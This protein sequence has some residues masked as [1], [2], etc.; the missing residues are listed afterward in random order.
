MAAGLLDDD[1]VGDLGEAEL[2]VEPYPVLVAEEQPELRP[3]V[4]RF[5][6][7]RFQDRSSHAAPSM[8]GGHDHAADTHDG[9]P[10]RLDLDLGGNEARGCDESA[11]LVGEADVVALGAI[12]QR[13]PSCFERVLLVALQLI[14]LSC[15]QQSELNDLQ[16]WIQS[17]PL[18]RPTPPPEFRAYQGP[19]ANS[20]E[21]S[22]RVKGR[23]S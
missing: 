20:G 17:P 12:A 18:I 23:A 14:S 7:R 1:L 13:D 21:C 11:M 15:R 19:R 10:C 8:R 2:S 4:G 6:D 16:A 22:S 3:H 9:K 5:C